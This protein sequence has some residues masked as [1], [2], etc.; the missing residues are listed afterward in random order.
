[1]QVLT[2]A[3]LAAPP[4][5]AYREPLQSI[6]RNLLTIELV[7]AAQAAG[8]TFVFDQGF[9]KDMVDPQAGT[10]T[11]PTGRVLKPRVLVGCDGVHGKIAK[12][13]NPAEAERSSRESEWGYYELTLPASATA[14]M[15][16]EQ[17]NNFHIWP[18]KEP[19]KSEFIVGLPNSDGS[20]TFTLFGLM[21]EVK[22]RITTDQQ[23][24]EYLAATYDDALDLS[25]EGITE[26]VSGGFQSIFLNEHANLAGELGNSG[27]F[28][29]LFGDAA[30]GMEQFLG[31]AVNAGFEGVHRFLLHF[32]REGGHSKSDDFWRAQ[33]RA[34][35]AL[36]SGVQALQHASHM[37]A[38]SMR[39]GCDDPVGKAVRAALEGR[40]G[41]PDIAASGF[42]STHDWWSFC[43]IPLKITET[44][45]AGQDAIVA[46]LKARLLGGRGEGKEA[47]EVEIGEAEKATLLQLAEPQVQALVLERARLLAAHA[48]QID[49]YFQ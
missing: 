10:I 40:F 16:K 4:G 5:Q 37:N 9:S 6:N 33:V 35:N 14:A 47:Q 21:E 46:G 30:L 2:H 27:T 22:G 13:V 20:I 44:I 25:T 1:V 45:V 23:M 11:L 39:D 8:V 41:S 32:A 12:L 43:E 36:N 17:F 15:S 48:A 38:A 31:L 28:V 34:R 26:A 19:H 42:E 49:A 7:K 18:G 3:P 24:R 29:F